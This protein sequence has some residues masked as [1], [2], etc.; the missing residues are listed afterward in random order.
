D[1]V[2]AGPDALQIL[3]QVELQRRPAVPEQVVRDPD[4][5]RDVLVAVDALR[6]GECD[7][8]RQEPGRPQRLLGEPAMDGVEPECPLKG[9]PPDRPLLLTVEGGPGG[10]RVVDPGRD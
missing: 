1:V 8:R 3:T 2:A 9:Q 6:L 5:R 10:A 4:P 7:G